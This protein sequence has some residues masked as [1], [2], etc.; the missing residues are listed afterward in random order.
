MSSALSAAQAAVSSAQARVNQLQMSLRSLE[1]A[2][3]AART[4]TQRTTIG[5]TL[6]TVRINL[7]QAMNVLAAAQRELN[8]INATI[9]TPVVAPLATGLV[10][11]LCIGIN[12]KGTGYELYGC[13]ND[14]NNMATQLRTFFPRVGEIRTLTDDTAIKPTK[15]NILSAIDWLVS[16]LV[17][18]Q[19]VALHFAGHGGRVRDTNGDE[20]S[21]LDSCLYALG[22]ATI[23]DDELRTT[24][25]ARIPVGCKCLVTLDCCHSGTAV[26]LRYRWQA[27]SATQLSYTEAAAYPKTAGSVLF[28]SGCRDEE[29]AMDTVGK[30][31]RPCGAMTMALLDTWRTYGAGIKLKHLLWDTRKYLKDNGYTQVPQ[32]ETGLFQDMN[33]V[34]DLNSVN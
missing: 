4:G 22:M 33:V 10:R 14:A 9:I 31:S 13:I 29:Y 1:M 20:A 7:N 12:Y 2:F 26:D 19:N 32:L 27:P 30:D 15:T 25:A 24:L 21:G 18:G 23:T 34:W 6:T 17:A 3:A 11:A 16:G 8:R 5:R 28:L